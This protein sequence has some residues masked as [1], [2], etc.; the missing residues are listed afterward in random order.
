MQ[1]SIGQ[2]ISSAKYQTKLLPMYLI[3]L[4]IPHIILYS[5]IANLKDIKIPFL[6]LIF[7]T[8]LI[9]FL[10]VRY[11][12]APIYLFYHLIFLI[13]FQ[14]ILAGIGMSLY[15]YQDSGFNVKLLMVYKEVFAILF[16][17]MLYMRYK[18]EFKAIKFEKAFPL[19]VIWL[20][21]SFFISNANLESKM[22]YMRSFGIFFVSYFLGRFLFYSLKNSQHK[23]QYVLKLTVSMGV[24][25]VFVGFLFF[26]IDR[27]S[28]I[29]KEWFSLGYIM[30]AKGTAYTDY[31]DFRTSLGPYYIYRMF[32]I[33]FDAINLSYFI[34]AAICCSLLIKSKFMIFI[35]IFLLAGLVFTFGKGSIGILSLLTMWILFLYVFKIN[36][37]LFITTFVG[38]IFMAFF[39]IKGSGFR[40]SIIVHFDGF[41]QPLLNS[42]S[43]PLG[44]GVGSGGVYYAMLNNIVAWDITHMGAESFFGTLIYQ[45]GLPGL[46]L[47]LAFFFGCIKY[48]LKLAYSTNKIVFEYIMYSGFIFAILVISFFQEAT[49]G[50][51]YTGIL[52]IICGFTISKVQAFIN[53]NAT[54]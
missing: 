36:P 40:S 19:L 2:G 26:I 1:Y 24:F 54:T 47:Y 42:Y 3:T 20:V 5:L 51:N 39:V 12:Q 48:L 50:L 31:P 14:N 16:V 11:F 35:R 25:S 38:F 4:L 32:S 7:Y 13:V 34:L 29:W 17:S 44:N 46:I 9:A 18:K 27:D 53:N 21:I 6:F 8:A 15:D 49:F 52:T 30:E 10:F 33:F 45:L 43:Q 41:I 22:Y 28:Y 23:I 37:R